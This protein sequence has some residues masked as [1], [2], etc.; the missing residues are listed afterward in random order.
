[1]KL[2]WIVSG[3]ASLVMMSLYVVAFAE[4]PAFGLLFAIISAFPYFVY[5]A[6]TTNL[7]QRF[8]SGLGFVVSLLNAGTVVSILRSD[9]SSIG[10]AALVFLP[11]WIFVVLNAPTGVHLAVRHSRGDG[12]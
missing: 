9:W 3:C 10:T 12:K 5:A 7:P 4:G 6:L 1:M 11:L 8:Y 2:T